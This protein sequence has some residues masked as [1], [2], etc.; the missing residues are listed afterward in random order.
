MY[1]MASVVFGLLI[2]TIASW[3]RMFI[4]LGLSVLFA[5]AVGIYA[6]T[7][8]TAEKIILPLIDIFQTLPILA[9]FPF[10]IFVVILILPSYW[11]VNAAVIFL[12]FTS[13]AW[14][15]M[16][17]V[18]EAIKTVPEEFK[19]VAKLYK[20]DVFQ[21]L[22]RIYIPASLPRVVQQSILS[23][24][25]GLFYLVT[26][27]IFST[28]NANYAVK[29]GIGIA[30]TKLALSSAPGHLVYYFIGMAIFILFV[31]ATRFLFFRPM[32]MYA[33]R[34]TRMPYSKPKKER[35]PNRVVTPIRV[36]RLF[37]KISALGKKAVHRQPLHAVHTTKLSV[38]LKNG[39]VKQSAFTA[40]KLWYIASVIAVAAVVLALYASGILSNRIIGYE[41]QT[42]AALAFTFARVWITF[43]VILAIAIPVCVYMV[44]MSKRP[45]NFLLIFQIIASI[46]ATLVLPLLITWTYGIP[47]RGEFIAFL[48]FFLS[49]IWYVIFSVIAATRT[50]PTNIT[51]VKKVF[52]V[53]GKAA[54]KY[55]YVNALIPGL[56]TGSITAIAAEWNAS[57]VAEYFTSCGIGAGTTCTTL[58][59]VGTGIGKLLDLSLSTGNLTLM[60]IGLINFVAMILIVNTFVWKRFYKNMAKIYGG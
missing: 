30:L 7:H 45:N 16:F 36:V 58:T 13:M 3:G 54:W 42:L 38:S 22:R 31:I 51:E 40:R 60:A 43:V 1:V 9:F 44:F 52:N 46:P 11:G 14:N 33:N 32:E 41:Y 4:A 28:G 55:V 2:D 8:K 53:N 56:I 24:S 35:F 18:Y 5:L 37:K 57:I 50:L 23:W 59:S 29:Y 20:L 25:I 26:S 39:H 21:R 34:Y 49:G 10:A 19:E 6:A 12:I 48:V 47:N 17:G 27:E 15:I